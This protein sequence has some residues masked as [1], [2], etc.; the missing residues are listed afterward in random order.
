MAVALRGLQLRKWFV[1]NDEI[2]V[3]FCFCFLKFEIIK[4]G[5]KKKTLKSIL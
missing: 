3:V 2:V 5:K 1:F 4:G